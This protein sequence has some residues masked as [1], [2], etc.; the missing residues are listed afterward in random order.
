MKWISAIE[1]DEVIRP[2]AVSTGRR[3][4]ESVKNLSLRAFEYYSEVFAPWVYDISIHLH[5]RGNMLL[6]DAF[7]PFCSHATRAAYDFISQTSIVSFEY[8]RDR[9]ANMSDDTYRKFISSAVALFV[10]VAV[11]IFMSRFKITVSLRKKSAARVDCGVQ[12]NSEID[13]E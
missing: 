3:T 2:I 4:S 13:V 10:C 1:W 7:I 9:W 5:A 6:H 12:A 11:L 8:V